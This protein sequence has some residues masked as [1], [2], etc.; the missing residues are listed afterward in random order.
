M[1]ALTSVNP[2]VWKGQ[3]ETQ[4]CL[5]LNG[6]SWKAGQFLRQDTSGLLVACASNHVAAT[7]GNIYMALTDQSDPGNSTTYAK[8]A[9]VTNDIIFVGNE[10]DTTATGASIGQ[11]AALN[12]GS[13]VCTIDISN[14][15]TYPFARICGVLAYNVEPIMN[16]V[17]DTKARLLF[18]VLTTVIE[19]VPQA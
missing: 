9:K 14:G 5:I 4:Q 3:M 11:E 16:A 1:A 13:N 10:Y 7:G 15:N 12:V 2:R 8:V 19:A 17:G 18:T 6:Q